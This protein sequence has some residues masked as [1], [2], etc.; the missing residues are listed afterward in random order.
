MEGIYTDLAAELR[1]LDPDIEGIS[2]KEETDGEILIKRVGIFTESAAKKVNK[3]M[4]NYIT[5]EANAL[6]AR[7]QELF[8]AVSARLGAELKSLLRFGVE[9]ACILVVGLG[10]RAVTPDSLGPRTVEK[11]YVTR[12]VKRYIPEAFSAG[13]PSVAAIAPGV[14]G[15]TGVETTDIIKGV[16]ERTHPNCIIAVDALASRRAE[17]ISSTIQLSDSGITPGSGVGNRREDVS[18]RTLGVPVIAIGVPTVVRASTIARDI[19]ESRPGYSGPA[20]TEPDERFDGLIVTPKEIDSII[21]DMSG[22]IADAINI[23]LFGDSV[24]E[25]RNILA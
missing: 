21:E 24:G 17:R 7:P 10:N 9:S 25:V 1:E 15:M 12:H 16:T 18:E 8:R 19:I 22:I 14:L 6:S 11:V 4:G 5:L 23:A 20:E 13:V 2:E 3:A